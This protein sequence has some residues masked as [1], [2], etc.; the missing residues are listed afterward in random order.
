[1]I[2]LKK[3]LFPTDFSDCAAGAQ[4]FALEFAKQ[5]GAELHVLHIIHDLSLEVPEFGMGLAFPAYVENVPQHRQEA[6]EATLK[7]LRE[8]LPEGTETDPKITCSVEFGQPFLQIL[9]YAKQH[10]IDLIV[11]GTHGR[12]GLAHILL[13]SVAERIVQKSTCPVLTIPPR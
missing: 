13:G 6:R 9:E 7:A 2:Q 1:M 10:E 3:I 12:T 4:Q 5:F 11:V 8:R